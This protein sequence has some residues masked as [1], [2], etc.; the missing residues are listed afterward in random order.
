MLDTENSQILLMN[1][2]CFMELTNTESMDHTMTKIQNHKIIIG[3]LRYR[4][5]SNLNLFNL[6]FFFQFFFKFQFQFFKKIWKKIRSQFIQDTQCIDPMSQNKPQIKKNLVQFCS[7]NF[8]TGKT[9][10]FDSF[11]RFSVKPTCPT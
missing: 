7:I 11:L 2:Q 10:N 9:A 3:L 8:L 5:P 1:T 6:K 4:S